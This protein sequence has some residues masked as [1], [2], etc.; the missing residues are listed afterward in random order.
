M[1]KAGNVRFSSSYLKLQLKKRE[2][3]HYDQNSSKI[4]EWYINLA[5]VAFLEEI[6]LSLNHLSCSIWQLPEGIFS[7][8]NSFHC[9]QARKC[10]EQMTHNFHYLFLITESCKRL[11]VNGWKVSLCKRHQ[12]EVLLPKALFPRQT[13]LRRALAGLGQSQVRNIA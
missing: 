4:I 7:T 13:S 6:F 2:A 5:L 10:A 12:D 9:R 1:W 11:A 8:M 3:N